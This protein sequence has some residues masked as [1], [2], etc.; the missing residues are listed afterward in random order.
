MGGFLLDVPGIDPFP[1]DAE[2][3]YQLVE[4]GYVEY[5]KLDVEDIK[6]KSKSDRMS[7]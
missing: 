6:D 1:I 5:P 4:G 2:Q 7:R 3:L